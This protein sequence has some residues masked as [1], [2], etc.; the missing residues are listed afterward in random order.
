MYI[1]WGTVVQN[2]EKTMKNGA[3]GCLF[4]LKIHSCDYQYFAFKLL[5]YNVLSHF[6]TVKPY[7]HWFF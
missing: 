4:F 5:I 7:E 1:A 2:K 3:F 6:H